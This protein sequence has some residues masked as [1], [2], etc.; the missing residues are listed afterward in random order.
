MGE[1]EQCMEQDISNIC[2]QENYTYM[3]VYADDSIIFTIYAPWNDDLRRLVGTYQPENTIK[4]RLVSRFV[5]YSIDNA[6]YDITMEYDT[7]RGIYAHSMYHKRDTLIEILPLQYQKTISV[8]K[9]RM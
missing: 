7:T 2:N 8:L 1:I 6:I 9:N 3:K 5:I 4:Y